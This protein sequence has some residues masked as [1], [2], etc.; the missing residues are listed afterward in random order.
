MSK[1][2]RRVRIGEDIKNYTSEDTVKR[3]KL[4]KLLETDADYRKRLY[5]WVMKGRTGFK[6]MKRKSN[7]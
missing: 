7:Y 2:A 5:D 4:D 3:M 1:V 6:P